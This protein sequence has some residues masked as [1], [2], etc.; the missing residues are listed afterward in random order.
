MPTQSSNDDVLCP[1]CK[2][3]EDAAPEYCTACD[4]ASVVPYD[5]ANPT[6]D[7]RQNKD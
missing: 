1:W 3:G 7:P 6:P 2:G 5:V 4:G